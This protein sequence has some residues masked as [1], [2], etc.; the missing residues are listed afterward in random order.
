MLRTGRALADGSVWFDIPQTSQPDALQGSR[1]K[2]SRGAL[3]GGSTRISVW[4][5]LVWFGLVWFGLV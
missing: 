4:F 2:A 3:G 5:G 1:L